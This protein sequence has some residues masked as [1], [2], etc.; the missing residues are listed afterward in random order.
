MAVSKP[1]NRYL[2]ERYG[3]L[4]AHGCWVPDRHR[5]GHGV[6]YTIDVHGQHDQHV[7]C[8]GGLNL[9]G[10]NDAERYTLTQ[11]NL[12]PVLVKAIQDLSAKVDELNEIKANSNG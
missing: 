12:I 1:L 3:G 9:V 8:A 2:H 11:T 10:K 7:D 6:R 4:S 5:L